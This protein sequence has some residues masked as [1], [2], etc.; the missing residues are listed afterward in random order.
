MN[1]FFSSRAFYAPF[2]LVAA[3]CG[4]PAL[5]QSSLPSRLVAPTYQPKPAATARP[6][7]LGRFS[8]AEIPPG[9]AKLTVRAASVVV[10][11]D[12][13]L[14]PEA[15]GRLD[16][17]ISGKAITVEE[18]FAA[19]R[20]YETAHAEA[21]FV[22]TRVTIPPQRLVPGGKVRLV[23][24]NGAIDSIDVSGLPERIRGPV[25]A[26]VAG[27]VGQRPIRRGEIESALLIAGDLYALALRSTFAPGDREGSTRLVLDGEQPL[28]SG[29]L[30]ADNRVSSRAGSVALAGT[31]SLNGAAG[32]GEQVYVAFGSDAEDPLNAQ[33]PQRIVA[34]GAVL[35]LGS[36]GITLS[37]EFAVAR[38]FPEPVTNGLQTD[39]SYMRGALRLGVP[40]IRG[41][42]RNL[43]LNIGVEA[44]E[45]RVR[46]QTF[47]I[48]AN[49][50]RY[51]VA[52]FGIDGVEAWDVAS[53][54]YALTLSRG[55]AGR[56]AGDAART[57]VP[58][59]RQG[60]E[61]GFTKLV[62]GLRGGVVVG[63]FA[64]SAMARG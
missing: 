35:P 49:R 27:L 28:V 19:A 26:R 31:V 41:V 7:D 34:V 42:R 12:L 33:A 43:A 38:S 46:F 36:G 55:L 23:V 39:E 13:N 32:F 25:S 45:Q 5:A 11:G 10:D 54:G 18:L 2:V 64:F 63:P 56:D 17:V 30:G 29:S 47:A 8:G 4:T 22:L 59:T 44:I 58:L 50:D 53:L 14:V 62:A 48:D 61:P 15:R 52:R 20:A 3:T 6:L 37:P 60:A 57:G 16:S 51:A 9:A 21:G 1:R 24:V 40:V